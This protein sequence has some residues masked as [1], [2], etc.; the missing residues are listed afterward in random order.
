MRAILALCC[1]FSFIA[2]GLLA[3][4]WFVEAATL[5]AKIIFI[6]DGLMFMC[7]L[8]HDLWMDIAY[9]FWTYHKAA[10]I[11]FA[12]L[13]GTAMSAVISVYFSAMVSIIVFE[14]GL[15]CLAICVYNYLVYFRKEKEFAA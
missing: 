6:L 15:V 8:V 10:T 14:V 2:G 5:E 1:A 9:D 7:M 13:A 4:N 3:Q 12:W 11:L